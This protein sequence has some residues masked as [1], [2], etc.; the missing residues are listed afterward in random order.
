[1]LWTDLLRVV[2]SLWVDQTRLNTVK[3]SAI[4]GCLVRLALLPV[5]CRHSYCQVIWLELSTLL[6]PVLLP[7][8]CS[9]ESSWIECS[10]AFQ[11]AALCSR[12]TGGC[13]RDISLM[14]LQ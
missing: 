14:L 9:R 6:R 13:W 3:L 7:I 11:R 8:L 10:S 2:T 1:M 4:V 12:Q 5:S